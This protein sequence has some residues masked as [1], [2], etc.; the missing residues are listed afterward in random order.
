M[1][2]TPT[3]LETG[4][5]ITAEKL[6]HMEGGIKAAGGLVLYGPYSVKNADA[7]SVGAGAN[8]SV[9]LKKYYNINGDELDTPTLGENPNFT[10]LRDYSLESQ[11]RNKVI[12]NGIGAPDISNVVNNPWASLTNVGTTSFTVSA[13]SIVAVF[14]STIEFPVKST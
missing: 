3:E 6:N 7:V 14:Y 4:D 12:I 9:E 11:N 8:A 10:F 5:V 1:A 2:Y 13:G